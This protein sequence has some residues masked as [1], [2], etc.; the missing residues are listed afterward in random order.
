[1]KKNPTTTTQEANI[2]ES[3]FAVEVRNH[4]G[5]QESMGSSPALG[6]KPAR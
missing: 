5:N 3:Q 6:T 4:A 1:M 2:H